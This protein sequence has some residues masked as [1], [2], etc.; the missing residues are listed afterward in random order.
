MHVPHALLAPVLCTLAAVAAA[1]TETPKRG[2]PPRNGRITLPPPPSKQAKPKPTAQESRNDPRRFHRDVLDLR[3][4]KV[5]SP[6]DEEKLL[7]DLRVHYEDPARMAVELARQCDNDLLY[8]LMK[9]VSRYGSS[10]HAEQL[11]FEVVSRPLGRATEEV[12]KTVVEKSGA[13]AK[14]RLF[15]YLVGKFGPARA[16][17]VRLLRDMLDRD[18]LPRLLLLTGD[19]KVDIAL[20]A[21]DLLGGVDDPRARAKLIWLLQHK[22]SLS[23][24]AT[25]ALIAQ[26]ALAAPELQKVVAAPPRGRFYGYACYALA[27][28]EDATGERY[29]TRA[30]VPHVLPEL[31][32]GDPF[33]RATTAIA[34]GT[35]AYR[36]D[37]WIERGRYDAAIVDAL[38]LL[39]APEQFVTSLQMLQPKATE[40]LVQFTGEDFRT[41]GNS[42]R[43]WWEASRPR[44]VGLHAGVEVN[45]ANAA[46]A[47][48]VFD[49]GEHRLVF[50]GAEV[51]GKSVP[52]EFT[53]YVL[54]A[55]EL[56]KLVG[57]LRQLGCWTTQKRPTVPMVWTLDLRVD[58][59][60][61]MC[62]V[63]ARAEGPGSN[64]ALRSC[65]AE[66]ARSQLWQRHR[67]PKTDP[68]AIAF[69][70]AEHA[71]L[72]A[73]PGQERHRLVWHVVRRL[74]GLDAAGRKAALD[75]LQA[76]PE[77]PKVVS[78]EDGQ[79]LVAVANG[80]KK[81]D[82]SDFRMLEVAL[83]APG[84]LV[85]KQALGVL[86]GRIQGAGGPMA[87]KL[88]RLLGPE[89]VVTSIRHPVRSIAVAAMHDAAASRNLLAV[90]V[91]LARLRD[92]DPLV[93]RTVVYALGM[94]R[95]KEALG[96]LLA[97]E[98]RA[99]AE[100][101]PEIWVALG[102]IGGPG[103]A[104][105][106]QRAM[107]SPQLAAKVSALKAMGYT[108]EPSLAAFLAA[109]FISLS[110]NPNDLL[111]SQAQLSLRHMGPALA[112]P[113]LRPHLSMQ[114]GPVRQ[115]LV[116]LLG[117][118]HD[119]RVV[120]D[121]IDLLSLRPLED[122]ASRYL[123]EITGVD[124]FALN[125]DRARRLQSW[126]SANRQF[127]RGDWFL[128]ALHSYRVPTNLKSGQL[129]AGIGVG[130]V[131]ELTR[132]LVAL[133]VPH[134]RVMAATLLRET[135]GKDFTARV[136]HS[137]GA[138]LQ[139]IADRYRFF[140]ETEGASG[141]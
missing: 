76:I 10:Y 2:R 92:D 58:G 11:H 26:G 118:M 139:A 99:P 18:D 78:E 136:R 54:A 93:R 3:R 49:G 67:D 88:F 4:T 89:R 33:V 132:L 138:A 65:I 100:V 42:W 82:D 140:A 38:L 135:T 5:L 105:L 21:V 52:P 80:L 66:V 127:G 79:A 134:L 94:L 73:H 24:E 91:L 96:P 98:P 40:V 1:Q 36:E 61:T 39:V 17:A 37:G 85:W 22:P 48:L 108:E 70:R 83:L 35:V 97:L 6:Q 19:R 71:W 30:M 84:D 12:V 141:K 23:A 87:S 126:Y 8:G 53:R 62:R 77:L 59:K 14:E 115:R 114:D 102:R 121:L 106:L 107:E 104:A 41:N 69:W 81:L 112:I 122:E 60:R 47:M 128:A 86:D 119:T 130:A 103:V 15:D 32:G 90:P 46:R 95:A 29:F 28:L 20:K 57:D 123:A 44:F 55:D 117:E 133:Q 9:V 45:A 111:A 137:Q 31:R 50:T 63:A 13:K 7:R 16:V 75:D 27:K 124:V 116:L 101:R 68:D 51:D 34:A 74:P 72:A 131:P 56:Q 129:L 110:V 113:A 109:R 125:Q 120:Q 25:E 43:G 64:A